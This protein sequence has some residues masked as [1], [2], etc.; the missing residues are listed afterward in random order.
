MKSII[1][2]ILKSLVFIGIITIFICSFCIFA[3]A[4]NKLV[5]KS[6]INDKKKIAI[7]FDDGPHPKN[8]EKILDVLDK[9]NVKSTFFIVG[10]NIKNYPSAL[11]KIIEKGHE[12]GNHTYTH[13]ILKSMTAEQITKELTDTEDALNGLYDYSLN[14]IRPPCGLYDNKLLG[15]AEDKGYKIVLWT[16]DTKDWAHTSVNDMVRDVIKNVK[17]GDIILF[18]DYISGKN[19]TPEALN[20]ILPKLQEMGFNLVTVSELLQS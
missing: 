18:H 7:T 14:L 12:I 19:N 16:I 17:S 6:N 20:I 10:V 2:K 8:T 15:I 13:S 3:N 4:E 5:F 9:Y 1:D 11:T